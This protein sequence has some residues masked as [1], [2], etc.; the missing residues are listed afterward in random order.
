MAG[1]KGLTVKQV[2]EALEQADGNMSVAAKSLGVTHQ[3]ISY[4][5]AKSARLQ[6][7]VKEGRKVLVS[8]A[9]NVIRRRLEEGDLTAAIFTLKTQGKGE[10]WSESLQLM[11]ADG[12]D[13]KLA[14]TWAN[15]EGGDD[16]D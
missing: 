5:V 16:D 6:R 13:L 3:A 9:E 15:S 14:V 11:G 10:G 2:E 12:G 4:H 1:P 8:M 7:V